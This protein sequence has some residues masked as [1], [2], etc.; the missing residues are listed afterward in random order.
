MSGGIII[1]GIGGAADGDPV[2]G[3]FTPLD[4]IMPLLVFS[5]EENYVGGS[6]Q[7][8]NGSDFWRESSDFEAV[9]ITEDG[10]IHATEGAILSGCAYEV[11]SR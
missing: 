1:H 11:I 8:G 5:M 2:I 3:L 7:S 6:I 10:T 4:Y 9:F